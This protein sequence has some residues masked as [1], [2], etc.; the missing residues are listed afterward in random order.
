MLEANEGKVIADVVHERLELMGFTG[1]VRTTSQAVAWDLVVSCKAGVEQVPALRAH[2]ACVRAVRSEVQGRVG[3]Q[4]P[5]PPRVD[6]D[7]LS[8]A[9]TSFRARARLAA[10]A[11]ARTCAATVGMSTVPV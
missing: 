10:T 6:A 2:G 7:P 1:N 3:G 5:G 9:S 8:R 4:Q 11:T